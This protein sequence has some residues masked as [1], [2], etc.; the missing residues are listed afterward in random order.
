MKRKRRGALLGLPMT[1]WTA[2]F[3]G[4][5]L[6]MT[7]VFQSAGKVVGSFL[8]SIGRQGVIFLAVILIAYFTLG[9]RGVIVSQ[10]A[11][12]FLTAIGACLLFYKQLYKDFR[13]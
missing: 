6:L 1:L 8:L 13:H 7:I 10:A 4:I 11:A 2:V 3:V 5:V 9:Y 12:D